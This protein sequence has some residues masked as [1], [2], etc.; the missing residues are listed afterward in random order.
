MVA[1]TVVA[2]SS[3]VGGVACLDA[4]DGLEAADC[5]KIMGIGINYAAGGYGA[6]YG[7][8]KQK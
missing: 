3:V 4:L 6:S 8:M 7:I 1:S 2:A 5:Y